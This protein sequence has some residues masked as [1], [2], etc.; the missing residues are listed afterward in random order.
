MLF[1]NILAEKLRQIGYFAH[2]SVRITF[3]WIK[4]FGR[5][6]MN[7]CLIHQS[8][9][10]PM[11]LFYMLIIAVTVRSSDDCNGGN[12]A[13]IILLVIAVIGLVISMVINVFLVVQRKRSRCV[14]TII[15]TT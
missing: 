12:I 7:S 4:N 9:L 10:L 5:L 11:F 13:L 14:V 1:K 15:D 2:P 3:W 8:F 6:V